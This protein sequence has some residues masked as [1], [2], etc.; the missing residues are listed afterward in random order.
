MRLPCMR[1]IAL[2]KGPMEGPFVF[3]CFRASV[4]LGEAALACPVMP[5]VWG[6]VQRLRLGAGLALGLDE[7]LPEALAPG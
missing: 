5:L 3:S 1:Q 6:R 4:L 2:A 7:A